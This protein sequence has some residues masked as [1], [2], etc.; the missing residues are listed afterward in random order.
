[1]N[2]DVQGNIYV[3]LAGWVVKLSG[4][5]DLQWQKVLGGTDSEQ[6]FAVQQTSDE[7]YMLTGDTRSNDGDVFG[8]HGSSDFWVVKLSPLSSSTSSPEPSP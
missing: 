4:A 5:G 2:G 8:N 1:M 3:G 6:L 7:G